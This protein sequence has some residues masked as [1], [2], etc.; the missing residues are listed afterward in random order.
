[1]ED[2]GLIIFVKNPIPGMVKTRLAKTVGDDAAVKVYK[3][4]LEHT[5]TEVLKTELP[6]TVFFGNEMPPA[7]LW[8]AAGFVR[9]QQTGDTLGERMQNAFEE[10]AHSGFEKILIIGSDCPALDAQLISDAVKLLDRADFV[11]GPAQDGG[12]YLLGLKKIEPDI[13]A[14]I[15]WS[16]GKV[17][18]MTLQR[19]QQKK[20]QVKLLPVLSDID[21][22]DD[23]GEL[24]YLIE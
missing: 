17:L 24:R 16:T 15:P 7:D 21:H 19:L 1:M 11:L 3:Y 2:C 12:Y 9:K 14:E 18:E 23:L 13:F 5:K 22:E 8:S 6:A 10:M 4:L 20:Y